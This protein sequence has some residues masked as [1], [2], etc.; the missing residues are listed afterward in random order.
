MPS[1]AR[2]DFFF[3]CARSQL[4]REKKNGKSKQSEVSCPKKCW[5]KVHREMWYLL[6]PFSYGV[7]VLGRGLQVVCLRRYISWHFME[8]RGPRVAP[9]L[10]Y[11]G[12]TSLLTCLAAGIRLADDDL[13][14]LPF[15]LFRHSAGEREKKIY[16][17]HEHT[18][19]TTTTV[20]EKNSCSVQGRRWS[21]VDSEM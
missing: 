12:A 17:H 4:E 7:A 18:T 20:P 9:S 16:H 14:V 6:V 5:N 15:S 3:V 13:C 2:W 10:M 11:K 19:T 21:R 1:L 8:Q